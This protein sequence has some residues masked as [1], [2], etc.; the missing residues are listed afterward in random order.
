VTAPVPAPAV[1]DPRVWHG[2]RAES[3]VV[4]VFLPPPPVVR[5]PTTAWGRGLS[6]RCVGWMRR[7]AG[8]WRVRVLWG[9]GAPATY[10]EATRVAARE[11]LEAETRW[12]GR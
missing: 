5:G 8:G 4:Y 9:S 6:G 7:T 11:R 12:A 2:D 3:S 1:A 10:V